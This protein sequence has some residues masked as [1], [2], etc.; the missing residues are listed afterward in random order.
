MENMHTPQTGEAR[1]MRTLTVRLTDAEHAEFVRLASRH[2]RTAGKQGQV[3]VRE[4]IASENATEAADAQE[5][6][7]A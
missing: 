7:A 1:R 4:W 3:I 5:A 2:S 6:N